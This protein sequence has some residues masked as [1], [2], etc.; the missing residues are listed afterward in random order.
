MLL[1]AVA[2]HL[3]SVENTVKTLISETRSICRLIIICRTK[4]QGLLSD[5]LLLLQLMA[6]TAQAS[7]AATHKAVLPTSFASMGFPPT[8]A[9]HSQTTKTAQ[10]ALLFAS[11]IAHLALS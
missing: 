3:L 9:Q 1:T 10:L 4:L 7:Q 6:T 11:S 5:F 8:T 2:S